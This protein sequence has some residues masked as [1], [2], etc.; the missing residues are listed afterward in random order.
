MGGPRVSAPHSST[1]ACPPGWYIVCRSSELRARPLALRFNDRH[2]VAFRTAAGKP[3]VLDDRCAHRGTPL[4]AGRVCGDNIQC[5]YHGWEYAVDGRV[6]MI[7]ALRHCAPDWP[8]V[9]VN[10]WAC[11]EQDGYLWVRFGDGAPVSPRRFLNL[12]QPGWTTFRLRNVFHA[13]VD[14][15]LENF[16]DCPHATFVHRHWFRSPTAR[17][18][19]CVV[20]T[21]DDGAQAEFF[22][23]P[24]EKSAVW[25]LLA[26]RKGTLRH[27]DRFIAPN[28]SQVGYEFP[29]GL[30]Y[31]ITSSCTPLAADRTL[32]H[33]V[34]SFRAPLL[35]AL[36]RLYFEPLARLI[37]RQ[38]VKL[39]GLRHAGGSH[40]VGAAGLSTPADL[41]GRLIRHWRHALLNGTPPPPAGAENDVRITL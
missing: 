24:R 40:P 11:A 32:V 19:R 23:E 20:R 4:S 35:G 7:P 12:G 15:C 5:A 41:L 18:V 2:L 36:V 29:G 27:V 9:R 21:L 10:A 39:L 37:I 13:S 8:E 25:W 26:P 30:H 3:S 34:I 14:A 16:L 33:T 17:V 28:L 1:E 22:D 31:L 6:A 38:D